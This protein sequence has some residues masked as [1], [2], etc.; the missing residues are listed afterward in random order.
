MKLPPLDW[1]NRDSPYLRQMREGFRT[2]RF[3]DELEAAYK[4][5]HA[6]VFLLRMRWSLL[7]GVPATM[8]TVPMC[9]TQERKA[10][11]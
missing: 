8:L 6:G 9:S 2:L 3:D 5:Y 10:A 4:R 11:S 1:V 7:V